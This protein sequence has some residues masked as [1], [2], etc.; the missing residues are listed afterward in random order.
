MYTQS[1][2][3]TVVQGEWRGGGGLVMNPRLEFLICCSISLQDEVYF[4]GGGAAGGL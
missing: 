3:P 4:M 1:P 2:T